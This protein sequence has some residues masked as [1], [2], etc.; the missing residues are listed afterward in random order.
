MD[1]RPAKTR[2][3]K[4][5]STLSS[6]P[7]QPG[8]IQPVF[9]PQR[10]LS[11]SVERRRDAHTPTPTP[12]RGRRATPQNHHRQERKNKDDPQQPEPGHN[13][14]NVGDMELFALPPPRTPLSSKKKKNVLTTPNHN[15][16]PT[17][18]KGERP[19]RASSSQQ[20][21]R[22]GLFV[23]GNFFFFFPSKQGL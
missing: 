10:L 4:D 3:V 2:Y 20:Q 1:Q 6:N 16:K 17:T 5:P 8:L 9:L 19:A 11:P 14:E 23:H 13:K 18:P 21:C 15:T 22:G 12:E 7:V